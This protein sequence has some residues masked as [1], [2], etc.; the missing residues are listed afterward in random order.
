MARSILIPTTMQ[1]PMQHNAAILKTHRNKARPL[2]GNFLWSGNGQREAGREKS[3]RRR[4]KKKRLD[5]LQEGN[6]NA[7]ARIKSREPNVCW[8]INTTSPIK[9]ATEH[10]SGVYLERKP[11]MS[12]C[13][14]IPK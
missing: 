8:R 12:M 13:L 4:K 14:V 10:K 5:I 1:A 2:S 11:C 3:A 7:L 6:G 9:S